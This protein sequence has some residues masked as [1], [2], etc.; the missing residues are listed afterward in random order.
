MFDRLFTTSNQSTP[1]DQIYTHAELAFPT[2]GVTF[3]QGDRALH[4]PYIVF[5]MVSSVDG[6]ASTSPGGLEGLGSRS[7]RLLMQRLRA[8]VDAVLVG[9]ATLRVDPFIPTVPEHLSEERSRD[10][11]NRP[12]PLG[13]VV[14]HSGDLP[15][16]HR[17]WQADR[18]LR[19]VF[20]G[21]SASREAEEALS[22][23][24]E[25]VRLP[26]D[27]NRQGEDLAFM[28]H[29]MCERLRIKWLLVEGGPSLNYALISRRWSDEIFLTVSPRLVG[30]IENITAIAGDGYGMGGMGGENLPHLQLQSIYHH[31]NELYLRYQIV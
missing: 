9:G 1:S 29:F 20:L 25:V 5:N 16:D 10:F 12:Q 14:S 27:V 6:K 24:A 8:Q 31:D 21:E 4:R 30:G 18:N 23:R 7:D 2:T 11:P 13:M 15:L 26:K 3:V 28:L 19:V 17:F 22:L